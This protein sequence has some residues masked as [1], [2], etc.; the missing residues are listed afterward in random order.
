MSAAGG[1]RIDRILL[2]V[3]CLL[4]L[5]PISG[6]LWWR[7]TDFNALLF[8]HAIAVG[9][10]LVLAGFIASRWRSGRPIARLMLVTACL[11]FIPYIGFGRSDIAYGI[12]LLT[13]GLWLASA[14]HFVVAFPE[15]RLRTTAER[16]VVGAGYAWS[17]AVDSLVPFYDPR[18]FGCLDC[19]ANPFLVARNPDIVFAITVAD[20]VVPII[21]ITAVM[22][23]VVRRWMNATR[24][25][26]RVLSPVFVALI[27]NVAAVIMLAVVSL[28]WNVR[29]IPLEWLETGIF[30]ERTA[31]LLLPLSF[32]MGIVRGVLARSAVSNL[33]VRIG[34]GRNVVEIERDVAWALADPSARVAVRTPGTTAY[35][36]ASGEAI[37][38]TSP[39]EA[40]VTLI[41]G[42]AGV[43]VALV[44]DQSL[45]RD[46]PELLEAVASATALAIENHRLVDEV[47]LERELPVSLAERLQREGYRIG[48]TKTLEISVLMSDIRG[49]ATLAE[50]ADAHQLAA[51]LNEHRARM[52][53]IVVAHGGTVMQFVG[54]MVF[55]VFGAP[56]PATDHAS[57]AVSAALE[58]QAAQHEINE[59]WEV[60]GR[61]KFSIGIAVTTGEVAAA[62]LGSSDHV[63]YSVVGDVV[64]LAQRIQAWAEP[65]QVVIS[66]VTHEQ[67][68]GSRSAVQ[69]PP[70]RVKG[71]ATPVTAYRL[72]PA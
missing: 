43:S 17:L 29:A 10:S 8:L 22:V 31:L 46:Q 44:H 9:L 50:T 47:H 4:A 26:R 65:G 27:A 30:I 11:Y 52:S 49:Y 51:Q 61:A 54:D 3:A 39:A 13:S 6:P 72:L 62:L 69:L 12:G 41:E 15:G 37:D 35:V 71:R 36:T 25:E 7:A 64:N 55:A 14:G 5:I 59:H 28:G 67:L 20:G 2:A 16:I 60:A 34:Q 58:M 42:S 53:A 24:P 18:D 21:I 45:D 48:D 57:R 33:L 1:K 66:Q 23:L 63:E 32:A 68:S 19:P 56:D 70:A 40:G 38:L